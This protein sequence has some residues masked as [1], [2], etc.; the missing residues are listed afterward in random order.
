MTAA[1][2]AIEEIAPWRLSW[3]GGG[4]GLHPSRETECK[5]DSRL[6]TLTRLISQGVPL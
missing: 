2:A 1:R 4:R 3:V 6:L 5:F